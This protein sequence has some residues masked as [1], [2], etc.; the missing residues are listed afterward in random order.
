M[1]R[2]DHACIEVV[3]LCMPKNT[4]FQNN[5]ARLIRKHPTLRR[6]ERDK[7]CLVGIVVWQIAPMKSHA[8]NVE[9]AEDLSVM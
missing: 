8:H 6:R 7:H 3:L 5:R 9:S 2:H 4:A 1:I